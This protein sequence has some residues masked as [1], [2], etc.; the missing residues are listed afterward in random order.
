MQFSLEEDESN[1]TQ[2]FFALIGPV[3]NVL[4][5]GGLLV[6]DELECSMHPLLTR[7]VVELFHN[8]E[9]NPK[10]A[11]LIFAT[12]DSTLMSPA[13]LRRDQIWLMEKNFKSATEMFSLCEIEREKRPRKEESFGKNYLA[14][15]YGGVPIFGPA[16]EDA[17][18][19]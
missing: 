7:K 3:L 14:G 9:A 2:R 15:R 16:L 1:G 8:P 19:R 5:H 12:H 18:V 11:Q 4:D 10:G 6:V 17:E 13:L